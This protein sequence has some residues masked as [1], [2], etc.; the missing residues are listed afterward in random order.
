[1][2]TISTSVDDAADCIALC[3]GRM[4]VV[5]CTVG[6][7]PNYVGQEDA[8]RLPQFRGLQ[9]DPAVVAIGEIGIDYHYGRELRDRQIEFFEAQ[10]QIASEFKRAVVI[11]CREAVEDTLA[12]LAKFPGVRCVFH[13]FTGTVDEARRILDAGHLLGFTGPITYKKSDDL[14]EVVRRTPMDRLLVETDA[15]YLSPEPMRKHKVNEPAWVMHVAAGVAAVK[16]I[17]IEEVDRLTSENA[18]RFYGLA[19]PPHPPTLAAHEDP[20]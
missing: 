10:L 4:D 1:M 16:G 7:H 18:E 9:A 15:P 5:R 14:R 2:I 6:V 8:A 12:V 11:H 20:A 17:A 3:R 13:C 19:N